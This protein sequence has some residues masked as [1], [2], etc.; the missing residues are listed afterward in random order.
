ME[1]LKENVAKKISD[2]FNSVVMDCKDLN[3]IDVLDMISHIRERLQFHAHR[4]YALARK[5]KKGQ[6]TK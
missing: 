1:K 3:A 5:V 2:T 6:I 4:T